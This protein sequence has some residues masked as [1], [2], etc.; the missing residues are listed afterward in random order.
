MI[1]EKPIDKVTVAN[2]DIALR[3]VGITLDHKTIDIIIDMVEL[4]ETKGD[5]TSIDDICALQ[6]KH[7]RQSKNAL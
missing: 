4:I 5:N 2:L 7:C 6:W 1:T 3:R